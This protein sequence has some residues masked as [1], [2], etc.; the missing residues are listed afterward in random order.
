MTT[1]LFIPT[2]PNHFSNLQKIFNLY[3]VGTVLPD[4]VIVSVSDYKNVDQFLLEKTIK[5]NQDIRFILSE[6]VL[7]AGPNRQ[8]SKDFCS[9]DII[10]YQDSDD[11]PHN[12][13][14]EIIKYFFENY[15]ICHL[16]HSYIPINNN[17]EDYVDEKIDINDIRYVSSQTIRNSFF[18]NNILEE[19]TKNTN[20]YSHSFDTH[21]GATAIKRNILNTI[22]WKD[23]HELRNSPIWNVPQYK[24]AEDYEFCMEALYCFNKS[25]IINSKLYYYLT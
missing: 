11:L 21:G 9:K 22:K 8:V 19:C 16:N 18:P 10:I 20:A 12:Q 5:E 14:I 7:L 15:D 1:S 24:G 6:T 13:R 4:E 23:R 25:M 3:R 17:E 2:T